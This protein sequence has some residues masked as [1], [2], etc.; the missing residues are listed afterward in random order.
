MKDVV[1]FR[2]DERF[3]VGDDPLQ[4]I[5]FRKISDQ[6]HK[7][8]PWFDGCSWKAV[9]FVHID[10]RVLLRALR[11]MGCQAAETCSTLRSLPDDLLREAR[12]A[13]EALSPSSQ[14]LA[15]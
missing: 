5:I 12:K 14:A 3:A 7:G 8:Y 10:K 4:H 11:E 1:D 13:A 6:R 2:V 9:Y 15:A